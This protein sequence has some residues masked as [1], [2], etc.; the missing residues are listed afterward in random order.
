MWVGQA[1]SAS[2]KTCPWARG[3]SLSWTLEFLLEERVV[4]S[5]RGELHMM[6]IL[7]GYDFGK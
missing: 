1:P 6:G 4:G 3:K 5:C 7:A 2:L